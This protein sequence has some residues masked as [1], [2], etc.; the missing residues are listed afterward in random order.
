MPDQMEL[1]GMPEPVPRRVGPIEAAWEGGDYAEILRA[2]GAKLARAMDTT[3]SVRDLK[4]VSVG[5]I[6]VNEKL[7]GAQAA[8]PA[9][10]DGPRE[11]I[12]VVRFEHAS[13]RAAR[14][15]GA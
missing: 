3:E 10:D 12:S 8:K 11:G 5:L 1:P 7:N 9:A 15:S 14:M 4:G 2:V 6:D 13:R